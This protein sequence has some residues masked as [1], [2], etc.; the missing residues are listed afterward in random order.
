MYDNGGMYCFIP[1]PFTLQKFNIRLFCI[2]SV[3]SHQFLF[4]DIRI[5][6]VELFRQF[7]AEEISSIRFEVAGL[8]WVLLVRWCSPIIQKANSIYYRKAFDIV[9]TVFI[10]GAGSNDIFA[11]VIMPNWPSPRRAPRKRS[12]FWLRSAPPLLY[13]EVDADVASSARHS[14]GIHRNFR[15]FLK[16]NCIF[17]M[18]WWLLIHP[19]IRLRIKSL[20][21]R[22]F[23]RVSRA[24]WNWRIAI[25]LRRFATSR[26]LRL[27]C[28]SR[29]RLLSIRSPEQERR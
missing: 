20:I 8:N 9:E 27:C 16:L 22:M 4:Y 12:E 10:L 25:V 2:I 23:H 11:P 1:S 5:F 18:M 14:R 24:R 13:H 7:Q 21:N 3:L 19:Q 15:W 29:M 26:G 28:S 17:I 6:W